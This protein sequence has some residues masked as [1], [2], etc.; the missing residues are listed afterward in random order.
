MEREIR[1]FLQTISVD[2]LVAREFSTP[3]AMATC[4]KVPTSPR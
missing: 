1:E 4:Y 2:E 3:K